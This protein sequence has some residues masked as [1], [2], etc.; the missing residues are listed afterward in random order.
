MSVEEF[1]VRGHG[2]PLEQSSQGLEYQLFKGHSN[3]RVNSTN[4]R[5]NNVSGQLAVILFQASSLFV[6]N[7]QRF[8]N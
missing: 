1:K 2:Q 6:A 8:V 3:E 5:P 4:F 7:K